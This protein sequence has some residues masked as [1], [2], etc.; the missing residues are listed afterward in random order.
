MVLTLAL[1]G[2]ATWAAGRFTSLPTVATLRAMTVSARAVMAPALAASAASALATE[3]SE[4]KPATEIA[5]SPA[6]PGTAEFA[7]AAPPLSPRL[8]ACCEIAMGLTM[9]HML[10]T[11]L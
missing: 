2:Y 11:M 9:G 7:H 1:V 4:S 5:Q 8:A 10:I 3:P 6:N